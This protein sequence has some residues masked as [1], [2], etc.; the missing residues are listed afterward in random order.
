LVRAFLVLP[1]LS[2]RKA[3]ALCKA[4]AIDVLVSY[5]IARWKPSILERLDALKGKGCLRGVMLDSGAYHRLKGFQVD[6]RDYARLALEHRSLW[7]LLVA[8]D[9]IGDPQGSLERTLEFAGLYPREFVPVAQP[10]PGSLDPRRHALEAERLAVRGLLER[11]PKIPGGRLLGVGGLDGARRRVS[12]IARLVEEIEGLGLGVR[13][14]L[15]GVG[16]RIL[17]GLASRGLHTI[18]YSIDST[19]WLAE[20]MFRRRTVYNAEDVVEANARAIR[21]YLERLME[22]VEPGNTTP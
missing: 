13:L 19:G 3:E 1:D 9:S 15:F 4:G 18:I 11:A 17:R 6:P 2:A 22:A 10:P 16:A 7:D 5:T 8:P 12:Y 20:I 14:H 21:G